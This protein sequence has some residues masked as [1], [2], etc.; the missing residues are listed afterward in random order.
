MTWE[1]RKGYWLYLIPGALLLTVIIVVPLGWNVYLS[2]T[3]Y[4]GIKPPTWIG[5]ENWQKL[6][7]DEEFWR[8]SSTASPWSWPWW[9]CPP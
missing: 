1:S 4:R 5:L 7:Q 2:F 6:F 3:K 9:C 8:R